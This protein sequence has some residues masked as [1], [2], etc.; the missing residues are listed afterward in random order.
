MMFS[1]ISDTGDSEEQVRV[2]PTGVG[3]I[4]DLLVTSPDALPLKMFS[5]HVTG[6]GNRP[7][8]LKCGQFLRCSAIT[9]L[10]TYPKISIFHAV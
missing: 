6:P 9:D 7:C 2:L 3:R 8:G 1:S 10:S 4:Y 5:L